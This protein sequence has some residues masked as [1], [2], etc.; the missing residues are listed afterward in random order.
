[1]TSKYNDYDKTNLFLIFFLIVPF[2]KIEEEVYIALNS[3]QIGCDNEKYLY[4]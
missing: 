4:Q 3:K 2:S 1:M